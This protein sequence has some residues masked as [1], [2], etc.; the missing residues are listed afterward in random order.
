MNEIDP[1]LLWT[2]TIFGR[3]L[4]SSMVVTIF[5]GS[6][7]TSR[8]NYVIYIGVEYFWQKPILNKFSKGSY[9]SI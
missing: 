4:P 1:V 3:T 9:N 6:E 8:S 5:V 2:S 7:F